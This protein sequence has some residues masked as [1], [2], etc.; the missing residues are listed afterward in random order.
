[1]FKRVLWGCPSNFGQF[2]H[3]CSNRWRWISYIWIARFHH[4]SCDYLLL[5]SGKLHWYKIFEVM[6]T[7]ADSQWQLLPEKQ[8]LFHHV[9]PCDWPISNCHGWECHVT[10]YP[11]SDCC[12]IGMGFFTVG[13]AV[14]AS[15]QSK[16]LIICWAVMCQYCDKTWPNCLNSYTNEGTQTLEVAIA[17]SSSCINLKWHRAT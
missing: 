11:V 12:R 2:V 16:Y 3:D 17:E 7:G 6:A 15:G 5:A 8:L 13:N 1:M 9:A 4:N 10:K 14:W